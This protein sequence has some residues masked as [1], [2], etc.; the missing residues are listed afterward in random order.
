MKHQVVQHKDL[1][2]TNTLRCGYVREFK[3]RGFGFVESV[4]GEKDIFFHIKNINNKQTRDILDYNPGKNLDIFLWYIVADSPKGKQAA[5][6]W[7]NLVDVPEP[8]WQAFKASFLN[9]LGQLKIS[10]NR[11][12]RKLVQTLLASERMNENDIDT[13]LRSPTLLHS[14]LE[15]IPF[16][17]DLQRSKLKDLLQ[18]HHLWTNIK[19]DLPDWVDHVSSS[20]ML[21]QEYAD[22]KSARQ[23][24]FADEERKAKEEELRKVKEREIERTKIEAERQAEIARKREILV[25]QYKFSKRGIHK[26]VELRNQCVDCGSSSVVDISVKMG[27]NKKCSECG[28]SW[29]VSH[30]WSCHENWVDSRDPL[31]PKCEVCSWQK[32]AFCGSCRYLGCSTTPYSK[33]YR[34]IDELN[35]QSKLVSESAAHYSRNYPHTCEWCGSSSGVSKVSG[36]YMCTMCYESL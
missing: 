23:K 25:A 35:N 33:Y 27:P 7:D 4:F 21:P 15:V 9:D 11:N 6:I 12:L 3:D 28:T 32:C 22:L 17:N 16:C 26:A 2:S 19:L 31:T 13:L 20:L 18:L 29:Y 5:T 36:I 34:Y 24:L 10:F 1:P 8:L 14:P 30:C